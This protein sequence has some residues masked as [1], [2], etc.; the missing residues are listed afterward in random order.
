MLF[1]VSAIIF[2]IILS[3][4]LFIESQNLTIRS[5]KIN[6]RFHNFFFL[7]VFYQTIIVMEIGQHVG[8]GYHKKWWTTHC[9]C[10]PNWWDKDI[11][12]KEGSCYDGHD[13]NIVSKSPEKINFDEK[14]TFL[15]KSYQSYYFMKILRQNDNICS[16]NIQLWF[17]IDT[18][19]NCS[20][21]QAGDVVET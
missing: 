20:L 7:L 14:I 9:N 10:T 6:S 13:D 12:M 1:V 4:N 8:E 5:W 3:T 21:F 15:Q 18:Y 19:T 2:I 16:I 17:C 11:K